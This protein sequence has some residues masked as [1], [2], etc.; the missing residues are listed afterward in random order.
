M[1]EIL[2]NEQIRS[3][4]ELERMNYFCFEFDK[5][6]DDLPEPIKNLVERRILVHRLM[7]NDRLTTSLDLIKM[8][9]DLASC[10]FAPLPEPEPYTPTSNPI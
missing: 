5:I 6:T 8:L 10:S 4:T 7:R 1:N 2:T 3:L 9:A